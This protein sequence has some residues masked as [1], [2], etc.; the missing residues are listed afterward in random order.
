MDWTVC[1]AELP[2]LLT[3][4]EATKVFRLNLHRPNERMDTTHMYDTHPRNTAQK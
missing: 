3:L 2:H 1:E 4:Q